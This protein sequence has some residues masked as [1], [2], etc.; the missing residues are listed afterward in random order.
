MN[1]YQVKQ[2][3]RTRRNYR[4]AA[5]KVQRPPLNFKSSKDKALDKRKSS[6][7]DQNQ[8]GD[9]R[10]DDAGDNNVISDH[11]RGD[12]DDL[13]NDDSSDSQVSNRSPLE[14]RSDDSDDEDYSFESKLNL[15]DFNIYDEIMDK[16]L[17]LRNAVMHG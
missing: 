12:V 4:N 9:D 2:T 13:I 17:N 15:V 8:D 6:S 14:Y 7:N 5:K 1:S 16:F 10:G 11:A 3:V